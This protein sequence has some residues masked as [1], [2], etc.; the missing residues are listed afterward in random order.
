M[1]CYLIDDD[2]DDRD[3]FEIALEELDEKICLKTANNG[4]EALEFLKEA[5]YTPD[6]I[7]MDINM[8]RM[9]GWECLA[10]IKK[11]EKLQSVPVIIYTTSENYFGPGLLKERGAI[12][13]VTKQPGVS[14]LVLLLKNVFKKITANTSYAD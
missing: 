4:I 2:S 6:V 11:I 8:P 13:H 1:D 9:D 10:E 3:F 12:K 5:N 14:A 7:F